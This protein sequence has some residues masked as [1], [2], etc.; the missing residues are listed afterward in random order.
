MRVR[1]DGRDNTF[2]GRRRVLSGSVEMTMVFYTIDLKLD[3]VKSKSLAPNVA[4]TATLRM[5][6]PR[7]L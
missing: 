7:D 1:G 2:L 4:Q 6:H 5:G 3:L